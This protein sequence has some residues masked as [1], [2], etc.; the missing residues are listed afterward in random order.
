MPWAGL[1]IVRTELEVRPKY[2]RD[3]RVRLVSS[4]NF[5]YDKKIRPSFRPL[6]LWYEYDRYCIRAS[7]SQIVSSRIVIAKRT[8]NSA[9]FRACSYFHGS[10]DVYKRTGG[11]EYSCDAITDRHS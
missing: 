3:F 10:R 9:E 1:A 8:K 4:Q 2:D 7:S 5:R 6:K 11:R